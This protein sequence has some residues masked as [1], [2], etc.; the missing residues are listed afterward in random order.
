MTTFYLPQR[1]LYTT[2]AQ[3]KSIMGISGTAHDDIFMFMAEQASQKVDEFC[4]PRWFYPFYRESKYD[5]PGTSFDM[6]LRDDLLRLDNIVNG[7]GQNIDATT[8]VGSSTVPSYFLYPPDVLP[9][10]RI[11][12]NIAT[13]NVYLF[14]ST[15]QQAITIVGL[16]GY[17][18]NETLGLWKTLSGATVQDNPQSSV[19]TT[20]TVP[21]GY[22]QAGDTV[23][24]DSEFEIVQAVVTGPTNDTC[25][26]MRA[27]NGTTAAAHTQNTAIYRVVIHPV[28]NR[29]TNRLVQWYFRQKDA[30]DFGRL[31]VGASGMQM[32]ELPA[33]IPVDIQGDLAPLCKQKF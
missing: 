16:F 14:T 21:T 11:S 24:I 33:E 8:I 10:H 4:A 20:L 23:Y 29:A 6:H 31:Q 15:P 27:A 1:T 28:I 32:I 22:L 5:W 25:T 3:V 26:V 7:N 17:P 18:A 13:G 9:K 2:P 30:A 12:L 19:T